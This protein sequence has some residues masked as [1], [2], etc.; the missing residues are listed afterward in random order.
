VEVVEGDVDMLPVE[1]P[2]DVVL[3]PVVPVLAAGV[4]VLEEPLPDGLLV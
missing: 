1:E 4:V 3:L 2:G